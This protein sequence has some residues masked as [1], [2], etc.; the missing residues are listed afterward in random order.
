MQLVEDTLYDVWLRRPPH[1]K[2]EGRRLKVVE[3]FCKEVSARIA[4]LTELCG[5]KLK[6]YFSHRYDKGWLGWIRLNLFSQRM[7]VYIECVFF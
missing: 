2:A 1:M 4:I 5:T 6:A 7:N 3:V